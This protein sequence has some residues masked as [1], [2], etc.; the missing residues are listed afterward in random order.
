MLKKMLVAMLFC[1]LFISCSHHTFKGLITWE[2][3]DRQEREDPYILQLDTETR[4]HR[5]KIKDAIEK[6]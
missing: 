4:K 6:T 5:S 2:D 1:N 3:Y